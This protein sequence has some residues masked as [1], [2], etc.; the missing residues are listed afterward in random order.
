[1]SIKPYKQSVGK[2]GEKLAAKFL[3]KK[4]IEVL[5]FNFHTRYGEIDLIAK[6]KEEYVFVEVKTRKSR[7]HGEPQESVTH[8]K[9]RNL[10][11][12]AQIYLKKH[13]L[14]EIDWRIDVIAIYLQNEK[15]PEI[16]YIQN[17][18]TYF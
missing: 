17:A 7:K 14:E 5:E 12:T 6:D 9:Q 10:I 3:E 8:F 1:M 18:V 16:N 13:K 4:G 2:Q 15:E 11:R